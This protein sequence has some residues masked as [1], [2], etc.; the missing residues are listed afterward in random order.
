MPAVEIAIPRMK[1]A[2]DDLAA[3]WKRWKRGYRAWMIGTEQEKKNEDVKLNLLLT[4]LGPKAR[5]FM[6]LSNGQS[7]RMSARQR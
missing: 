1:Y 2:A 5:T 3:E 4:L 7:G 6:R